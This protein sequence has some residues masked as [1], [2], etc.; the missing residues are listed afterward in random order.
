MTL[1]PAPQRAPALSD[2][3]LVTAFQGGDRRAF[4]RLYQRHN[5]VV[6]A[7]IG[8]LLGDGPELDDLVQEVF[9]DSLRGLQHLRE[10]EKVR[11]W[12]ITVAVRK[13]R[14][15]IDRRMRRRFFGKLLRQHIVEEIPA[16]DDAGQLRAAVDALPSE[17][18][19]PFVLRCVMEE[20]LQDTAAMCDISTA[21]AKRRIAAARTRL[22]RRLQR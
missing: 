12:L 9:M 6:A 3:E 19:L 15:E 22:Q 21:T 16:D 5:R 17:L 18:R 11:S 10:G 2:A 1:G 14:R 7:T 13:T 20:S 8:R 4:E